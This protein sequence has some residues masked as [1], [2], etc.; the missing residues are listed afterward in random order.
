M[1][2][3]APHETIELHE[4]LAFKTTGCVKASTM[5]G[6]VTDPDLKEF[7]SQELKTGKRHIQ[8]LQGILQ[9]TIS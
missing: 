6:L 7:L 1:T 9:T 5:K 2:K 8:E 4:L 3:L